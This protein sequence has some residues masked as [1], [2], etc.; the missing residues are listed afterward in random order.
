MKSLNSSVAFF[1][2]A[3]FGTLAQGTFI[4][5]QQSSTSEIVWP[6]GAG[7]HIRQLSP[8]GQSFT[9]SLSGIGFVRLNLNDNDPNNGLG[10]TL[11]LNLRANSI[12]GSILAVTPLVVL[13]NGFTGPVNFLFSSEVPLTPTST[14]VFELV[15]QL[16]S[17]FWNADAGEYSYPGGI[18]FANGTPSDGSDMWFREGIYIVPEPSSGTLVLVCGGLA[19]WVRR[20]R[21]FAP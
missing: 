16:G 2:A 4:Y 6:Y 12:S 15:L 18:V 10:A 19:L 5:D 9:P 14:Y 3:T 21:N 13:S 20:K 17:D 7:A 8:Y 11:Y 1:L